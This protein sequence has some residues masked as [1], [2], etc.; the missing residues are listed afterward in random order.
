MKEIENKKKVQGTKDRTIGT[1]LKS[2]NGKVKTP[3]D[4]QITI[5][6]H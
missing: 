3:D 4:A 1:Q 5:L 2:R 6:Q